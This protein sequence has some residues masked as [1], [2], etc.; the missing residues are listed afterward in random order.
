MQHDTSIHGVTPRVADAVDFLHG[1]VA[2]CRGAGRDRLP[3]V[4]EL[5]ALGGFS[6]ATITKALRVLREAGAVTVSQRSGIHIGCCVAAPPSTVRGEAAQS[7]RRWESAYDAMVADIVGGVYLPGTLLPTIKEQCHRYGSCF[8]TVRKALSHLESTGKV[9][10]ERRRFRVF[11]PRS[12]QPRACIVAAT[13]ADSMTALR[14]VTPVMRVFWAALEEECE[15]GNLDLII[16]RTDDILTGGGRGSQSLHVKAARGRPVLG[17]I[18]FSLFLGPERLDQFVTAATRSGTPVAVLEDGRP[19]AHLAPATRHRL[20]RIFSVSVS[21]TAGEDVG[22]YLV[23]TG[24]RKVACFQLS[25]TTE[26]CVNRADGLVRAFSS[27]GLTGGVVRYVLKDMPLSQIDSDVRVWV[28]TAWREIGTNVPPPGGVVS[29]GQRADAD[30][31]PGLRT[32][33][34]GMYMRKL[35]APYFEEALRDEDITAWVAINDPCGFAA[36]DFLQKR[37]VSVPRRVSVV[38]FDDS[39]EAFGMGMSSYNFNV[40]SVVRAMVGHILSPPSQRS[41]KPQPPLE[42]P[43]R[44]VAREST[45]S[46]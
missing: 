32:W 30:H 10:E 40:P 31:V 37:N 14:T 5:S 4:K 33:A 38:G 46:I 15:R 29:A 12:E 18:T 11:Q 21:P 34:W 9:I 8:A 41:S 6:T 39:L 26:F 23:A 22:N 43:G 27:A 16:C 25:D 45:R 17:Y 13:W 1:Q 24:H 28:N 44:V 35:L 7:R 42:V 36:L 19:D 20:S 2:T 3:T